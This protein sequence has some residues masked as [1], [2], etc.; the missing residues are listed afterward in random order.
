MNILLDSDI[1]GDGSCDLASDVGVVP[2]KRKNLKMTML[3]IKLQLI[4]GKCLF[5]KQ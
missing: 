3:M 5:L 1:E 2:G 4:V